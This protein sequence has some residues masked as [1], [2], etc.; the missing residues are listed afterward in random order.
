MLVEY[1]DA[2]DPAVN[3]K[4]RAMA[5]LLKQG[6]PEG[7]EAVIPAYRN[8]SLIYDPLVTSPE[9][10]LSLL[11]GLEAR[12]HEIEIPAPRI[13]EIP[14]LYDGEFGPDIEVVAQHNGLTESRLSPSTRRTD[15]PIYMIGFTPGFCYLGGL[16]RRIH[17]PRRKTPRTPAARRLRGDRRGPDGHVP[18]RQS[19]RLADHRAD[20]ARLFA[21]AREN[22]FL[23]EAGDRI[24]FVPVTEGEFDRLCKGGLLMDVFAV[25]SPGPITTVQDRGRTAFL[26]RGVP[27]S[28]V[29]DP[30]PAAGRESA[31]GESRRRGRMAITVWGPHWKSLAPADVALAGADM[32]VTVNRNPSRGGKRCG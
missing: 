4:V 11:H 2:I 10:L 5:A 28:G 24:R 30:S 21:P 16:D 15:Y 31:G 7:V 19:R 29:L 3:E 32:A 27:L 8:L 22:P 6:L 17:T 14:V 18:R 26:D 23:Y 25:G 13:V 12:L 20:A 1:G 9:K